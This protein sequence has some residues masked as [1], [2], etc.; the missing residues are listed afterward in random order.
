MVRF[1]ESSPPST[2][3]ATLSS[4]HTWRPI[5]R[6]W[7]H[8][9]GDNPLDA[10]RAFLSAGHAKRPFDGALGCVVVREGLFGLSMGLTLPRCALRG[11]PAAVHCVPDNFV[12]REGRMPER[13]VAQPLARRARRGMRRVTGGFAHTP[14]SARYAKR[15][16]DEDAL[17]RVV[18]EGLFGPSLGLTLPRCRAPGPA[19]GCPNSFQTNLSNPRGFVHTSLSARYAK[20][21]LRGHASI[22]IALAC[23]AGL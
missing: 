22:S 6:P 4:P 21:P 13:T 14:L 18:R 15:R 10:H 7:L 12:A 9:R 1:S 8:D 16:F 3:N 5:N 11:Q 23:G 20:R 2:P 17:L 19:F